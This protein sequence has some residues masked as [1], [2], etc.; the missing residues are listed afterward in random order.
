MFSFWDAPGRKAITLRND[1]TCR[2]FRLPLGIC[3][4]EESAQQAEARRGIVPE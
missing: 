2:R 4:I 1:I 3:K